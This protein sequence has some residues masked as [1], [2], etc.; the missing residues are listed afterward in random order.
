MTE[1]LASSGVPHV[2]QN[3]SS[4]GRMAEP[5]V[6]HECAAVSFASVRLPQ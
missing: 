5:H 1:P 3:V 2:A 6:A 4:P